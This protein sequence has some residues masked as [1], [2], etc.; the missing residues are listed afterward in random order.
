MYMR[1]PEKPFDIAQKVVTNGNEKTKG[2]GLDN[3]CPNSFK[4][5]LMRLREWIIAVEVKD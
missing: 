4:H 3:V 2:I 1:P 5:M